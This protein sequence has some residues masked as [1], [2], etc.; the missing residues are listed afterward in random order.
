MVKHECLAA[1]EW[2]EVALYKCH[3]DRK[4]PDAAP[5]P[6]Y[7]EVRVQDVS[8]YTGWAQDEAR[9]MY[10]QYVE[11]IN[12]ASVPPRDPGPI[13]DHYGDW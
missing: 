13:P 7:Y 9:D 2:S 5:V 6:P 11:V 12:V 3:T 10:L 4:D 8:V 1:D